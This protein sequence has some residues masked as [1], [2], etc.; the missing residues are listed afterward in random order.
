MIKTSIRMALA[1]CAVTMLSACVVHDTPGRTRVVYDNDGRGGY[2]RDGN[3]DH[4]RDRCPP[5][6]RKKHWC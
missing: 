5:G 2:D 1:L 4:R 6:H 3:Y